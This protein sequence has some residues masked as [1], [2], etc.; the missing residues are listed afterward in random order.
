MLRPLVPIVLGLM[1]TATI[2]AVAKAQTSAPLQT[3]PIDRVAPTAPPRVAP[4]VEAPPLIAQTGPGASQT[5]RIGD[6]ALSGNLA[7]PSG[8]L[9][10]TYAPLAGREV[11]LAQIEEA[12]IGVLTAYRTAGYPFAAVDAGLTPRPDGTA[13]LTFRIT[14]GY[15]AEVRLEG[16]IGPAGTQVLRFLEPLTRSRPIASA[17]LERALLLASDIPGV[18]VRGVMRPLPTEPG[19]L[20]LVA[21]VA[22]RPVSGYLNLDNRG[23]NLAGP[24]QGL[25][26]IGANSFTEFGERTELAVFSAEAGQQDFAQGT[27]ET[28][29][30]A[31]GLRLRAW[32]GAGRARPG[33]QLA[34]IGYAGDTQ[35][36]GGALSY[37]I[38][39]RRPVSLSIIGQFD[40]FESEVRTDTGGGSAVASRDSVRSVRLGFDLQSLDT[41][42]P[43]LPGAVTVGSIRLHQ[44]LPGLGASSNDNAQATRAGSRYDYQ[45]ASF[46]LVRTQPLFEIFDGWALAIQG[47]AAGQYSNDVLPQVEKFYL[48]GSRLNRGFFAGQ[49]TGDSA[50]TYGV[51]LQLNT[52]FELAGD[53]PWGLT[54]RLDAQ[55]YAFRDQ[56]RSWENLRTDPNRRLVSY[57]VGVRLNLSD[58]LLLE[59]EGVRRQTRR[60][61][62]VAEDPLDRDAIF[63]RSLIRF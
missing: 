38:L 17:E 33:S 63:F 1:A 41:L 29:I 61:A 54:N 42:I 46:D 13:D 6:A 55:F 48:G 5:V 35:V 36:F 51:E 59:F 62:G 9:T 50:F 32:A 43:F 3:N 24:W 14:E 57:G 19:A 16:D 11:T 47:T 34:A 21:Q 20:Q 4:S 58:A 12:R 27:F 23:S 45:K 28:F 31:S 22:R 18:T 30:G 37:P 15:I 52:R 8:R 40:G 53:A 10:A 49:V 60:P 25:L 44:G 26:A 2:V 7:L 39:R 56:G